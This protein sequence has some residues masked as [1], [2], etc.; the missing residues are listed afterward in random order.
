MILFQ[1][2]HVTVFQSALYQTNSTVV[3]TDDCIIV[4]DPTWLPNEINE[5]KRYIEAIKKERPVYLYFTHGDFDHIIG[6]YAFSD[7][8]TIGSENLHN[9]PEKE[10][11]VEKIRQFY[12]DNYIKHDEPIVF[13]SIDLIIKEDGQKIQIGQTTLQFSHA[14]G[15]T[16]DGLF[17]YIEE[18]GVWITGDY[19]SD[20]EL[21][22]VFDS[23][24]SYYDTLNKA[25][26]L[27]SNFD[28]H[29]LIPG[30]GQIATDKNEIMKRIKLGRDYLQR[31]QIA[32]QEE[33]EK[34]IRSL[35]N[36]FL[37]PSGFTKYCHESNV[38]IMKKE[39]V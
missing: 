37:F 10:I 16:K 31:L 33:D 8:Q 27:L 26:N 19:L 18:L 1:N 32:V 13:P 22:I 28:N 5:I 20:F 23:V 29:L 34:M 12:N 4:V 15:H 11:K 17:L 6:Y 14:P 3:E 25:E 21:P 7:A 39:F 2:D 36:E 35:E 9:H 38:K 30:H 24:K